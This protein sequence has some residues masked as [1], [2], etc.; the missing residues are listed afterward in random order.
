MRTMDA[1]RLILL[2]CVLVLTARGLES[3]IGRRALAAEPQRAARSA[4]EDGKFS[5]KA[6]G[7]LV[8]PEARAA[9]PAVSVKDPTIVRYRDRWHTFCTVR[10]ASGKVDIVYLSFADWKEANRAPRHLL[11]LHDQYYCAPQVFYF[12]PHGRG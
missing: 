8:A 11:R 3:D 1:H 7:P 9:D 6:S 2:V 10:L 4:F 12:R 5:W